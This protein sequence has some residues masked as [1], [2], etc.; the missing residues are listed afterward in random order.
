MFNSEDYFTYESEY[1]HKDPRQL[2]ARE[3]LKN[4]FDKNRTNVFFS[5]QLEVRMEDKYYHWITNRAIRDLIESDVIKM[6]KHNLKTEGN[7]NILWH[8]SLRY[9]KREAKK[10]TEL[11]EE[12]ANPNISAA[13]GLHGEMMVLEGFARTQFVMKGRN[14][15]TYGQ[16]EWQETEHDLDFIFEKDK[17]TYGIEVKN[18]LGYM[19]Y[20]EFLIKIKM[21]KFL[22]IRPVFVTRMLPKNWIEELRIEG[23]FALIL[24]YQLYP[25]THKDL[26][27]RISQDLQLP[28]DSP[29]AIADGTMQRFINW[30]E[31]NM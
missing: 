3:E 4:F 5:R 13:I 10:V 24:K 6:E 7:I 25:W 31:K 11:V 8:K 12:Y 9:Y 16:K 30:H 19:D 1:Q 27:K 15:R 2:I 28:V 21:C 23:G 22:G 14:T 29:K 17:K 18:M 26:A 20:K